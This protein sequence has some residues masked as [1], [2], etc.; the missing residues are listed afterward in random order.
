MKGFVISFKTKESKEEILKKINVA[1]KSMS[2]W[3]I[4]KEWLTVKLQQTIK[5]KGENYTL[6]KE[7]LDTFLAVS[8]VGINFIRV[9]K[10]VRIK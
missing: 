7:F 2:L 3:D 4:R 8:E 6:I 5:L 9:P 1:I 10:L